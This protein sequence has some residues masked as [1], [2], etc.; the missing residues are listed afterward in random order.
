[1]ETENNAL[2]EYMQCLDEMALWIQEI[3]ERIRIRSPKYI[4]TTHID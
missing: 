4:R 2:L 3:L 1:M